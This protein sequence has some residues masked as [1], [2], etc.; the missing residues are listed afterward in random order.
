TVGEHIDRLAVLGDYIPVVGPLISDG[1]Q[2]A[3]EVRGGLE[4]KDAIKDD[5]AKQAAAA[6]AERQEMERQLQ[7]LSDLQAQLAAMDEAEASGGRSSQGSYAKAYDENAERNR[8][9]AGAG[10]G[11]N[12]ALVAGTLLIGGLIAFWGGHR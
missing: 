6:E 1:A 4:L 12:L 9:A 8:E 3:Q 5:A 7:Q 10:I 2:F 11:S